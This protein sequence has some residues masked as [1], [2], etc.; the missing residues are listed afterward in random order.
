M[1][2]VLP[3]LATVLLAS[4][5]TTA[6]KSGQT[7]DDVYYSPEKKTSGSEYVQMNRDND[8]R[9]TYRSNRRNDD[10][11]DDLAYDEDRYLR[12][13]VR[14]RNRWSDLDYYYS[15][16]MV[17]GYFGRPGLYAGVGM[18]GG[19]FWNPYSYWNTWNN[20]N[21]A[22]NPYYN[23]WNRNWGGHNVIVVNP[24]RPVYNRPRTFNLNTFNRGVMNNGFSDP[25]RSNNNYQ[26]FDSR[27]SRNASSLG[28]DLRRSFGNNSNNNSY[29]AP[30]RSSSNSGSSGSSSS[31]SRSS[32]P[33]R[34]F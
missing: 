3:I 2:L 25:K 16:P 8:D 9:P 7:P 4:S 21:F 6:Y 19:N 29:S 33:V 20:W 22:Y 30:S 34:R 23:P 26:S 5:C 28:N 24:G 11:R 13:K 15:D 27:P 1:K 10:Y 18:W 14:N 17:G 31:G 32:A 12:M